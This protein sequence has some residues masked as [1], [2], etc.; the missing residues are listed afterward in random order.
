MAQFLSALF[1][2]NIFEIAVLAEFLKFLEE[3]SES[4]TWFLS[5]G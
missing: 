5:S 3:L 2:S 4:F 1:S